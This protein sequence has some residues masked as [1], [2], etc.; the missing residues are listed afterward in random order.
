MFV[1]QVQEQ[2]MYL[3]LQENRSHPKVEAETGICFTRTNIL[4]TSHGTLQN[5]LGP[6]LLACE[7]R[8]GVAGTSP[9]FF[10]PL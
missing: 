10:L 8:H 5:L 3:R 9:I 2:I 7:G 6:C 4:N 1:I